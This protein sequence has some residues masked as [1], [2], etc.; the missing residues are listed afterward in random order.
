MKRFLV[1]LCLVLA[2]CS[3]PHRGEGEA[4]DRPLFDGQTLRGWV[5]R[6]G[7]AAYSV[8]DG[9]IVGETRPGPHNSFLC[10]EGPFADFELS[11]EFRVDDG[12]NSGIQVRSASRPEGAIER[13]F[14]YQIEIDPSER[15]WTGGLYE[16]GGRGWLADLKNDP[17]A[18]AAFRHGEW[19][20]MRVL[21]EGDRIQTWI[22]GVPCVD[23]R[24]ALT[25]SGFIALQVHAVGAKAEPLRVR[26]RSIVIRELQPRPRRSGAPRLSRTRTGSQPPAPRHR[27]TPESPTPAPAR[28]S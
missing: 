14:G 8:E 13:V 19:N 25:A 18:R 12:L 9:A 16:E 5:Q 23:H 11:L 10:T 3:A 26:W 4:S 1:G 24:D 28:P 21:C 6:G 22:N 2:A 27:T 15:A 17:V 7:A 20:A